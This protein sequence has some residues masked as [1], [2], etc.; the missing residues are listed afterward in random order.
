VTNNR[1]NVIRKRCAKIKLK[2]QK[3]SL[4]LE[5]M[6]LYGGSKGETMSINK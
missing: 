5:N 1:F 3:K 4:I 6:N 2:I